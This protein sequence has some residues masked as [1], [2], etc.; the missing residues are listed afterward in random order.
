MMKIVC[1]D[2]NYHGRVGIEYEGSK[3]SEPEGIKATKKLLER[4]RMPTLP[5]ANNA[6]LRL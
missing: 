5:R 6:D 2:H 4:V 3:L 1:V